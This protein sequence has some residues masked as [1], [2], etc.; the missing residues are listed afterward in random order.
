M[1]TKPTT[2]RRTGK[3]RSYHIELDNVSKRHLKFFMENELNYYNYL[4]NNATIRL[5]AFPE[6]VVALRE[7][8]GRL[9]S[10]VAYL[11]KNLREFIKK[12]VKEWPNSISTL[13]PSSAVQNGKVS[14]D[15]KK[16]MLFDAISGIGNIHPTMRRHM[17]SELLSTILPQADQLVQS[18]KNSTGQ[19]RDPVHM[20]MPK[21]YPERRHIQLTRDLV[22]I[23]YNRET[24]QSEVT[25]PYTDKPLIV[26]DFNLTEEKWDI[27]LI[28]QQPNISVTAESPWQIDLV[29]TN[30]KYLMDLTD[31]NV[32]AKKRKA[33]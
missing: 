7:G 23:N 5:R 15:E 21:Q 25:V 10:A 24:Q 8:Y 13:L 26:K 12:D 3:E 33:A 27:M 31:Q 17:A 29:I 18:H 2:A 30:H 28:R 19:M 9:W 16:L 14:I 22:K 4:V 1:S 20:L 11:G 6:E 32:Y